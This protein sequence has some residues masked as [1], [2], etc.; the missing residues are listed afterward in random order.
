[1]ALMTSELL[2]LTLLEAARLTR[3]GEVSA[4]DLV[5]QSLVRVQQTQ[6]LDAFVVIDDEGALEAAAALDASPAASRGP[7]HGIPIA[8]KDI[9]DV[10]G[11][12]TRRGSAAFSD[13]P[14]AQVDADSVRRLR[15]AGA[16]IVGKTRTHELACG[17]YTAPTGNPWDPRRSAGGSSGGSGAAVA[18]GAV[19]AAT[20]SDTGGS[21]RIPA[22]VCGIVG[23]KPTFGRVSRTGVAALAW[24]LDH[25]GPLTRT[26][27][28]AWLL[29]DVLAGADPRDPATVGLPALEGVPMSAGRPVRL[30]VP[31]DVFQDGMTSDVEAVWTAALAKLAA[32]DIELVRVRV[33][34]LRTALAAEFAIVLAEASAYYEQI[35][36]HRPETIGMQVRVLLEAGLQL[37][38]LTYLRAQRA[39]GQ[40]QAAFAASFDEHELDAVITPTL[41]GSAQRHEQ[42]YV[43]EQG[44]GETVADGFVRT[45]G[46]F[47][48]TGMPCV[49]LPAG[50][51]PNGLPVGV[52]LAC[53]PYDEMHLRN[54]AQSVEDLLGRSARP[55][56]LF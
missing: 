9:F 49:S 39:R 18:A 3:S 15:Q 45:T 7:L 16:V 53:R 35:L 41:P 33:P 10:A 27:G 36:H 12:P 23:L 26:V 43:D 28:D 55:P 20:G 21:I 22:A 4:R 44:M 32:G 19:F 1:M 30:G 25:I 51:A 29:L 50:L 31:E 38:A 34:A 42:V 54:V 13:A 5:A 6:R 52:Q 2:D 24:S 8:L 56:A 47:N 37:P 40:L 46:P 14:P 17:V 48:L 11:H